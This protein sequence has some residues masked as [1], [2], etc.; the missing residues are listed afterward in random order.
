MN[1]TSCISNFC[2]IIQISKNYF[3]DNFCVFTLF[4]LTWVI[5]S[6]GRMADVVAEFKFK[7]IQEWNSSCPLSDCW[8]LGPG[9]FSYFLTG[10]AACVFEVVSGPDLRP[11]NTEGAAVPLFSVKKKCKS[12][13]F[14]TTS[15]TPQ[16]LTD[17][18][19]TFKEND[20]PGQVRD[21][22]V[23]LPHSSMT[24][25]VLLFG[26]PVKPSLLVA[27][28]RSSSFTSGRWICPSPSWLGCRSFSKE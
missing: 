25:M 10:R 22:K 13:P 19:G 24:W 7:Y 2:S 6:T 20:L 3:R 28:L 4:I 11:P 27:R 16:N 15:E 8:H 9:L 12:S 18:C 26:G 23:F 5:I 21:L 1:G 17:T 14:E